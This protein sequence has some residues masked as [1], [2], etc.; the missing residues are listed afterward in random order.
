[1]RLCQLLLAR[2]IKCS[3][4]CLRSR[5]YAVLSAQMNRF[6]R[7]L[8]VKECVCRSRVARVCVAVVRLAFCQERLTIAITY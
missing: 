3:R 1:M 6:W 2:V 8:N 5:D 4:L 7:A